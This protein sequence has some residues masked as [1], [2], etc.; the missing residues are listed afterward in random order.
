MDGEKR[1]RENQNSK[2]EIKKKGVMK[3]RKKRNKR[4]WRKKEDAEKRVREKIKEQTQ[5]SK[6]KK[7]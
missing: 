1:P 3:R 5:T 7:E 2:L 6:G 4:K